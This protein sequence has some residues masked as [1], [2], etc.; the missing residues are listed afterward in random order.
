M[1]MDYATLVAQQKNYIEKVLKRDKL[2]VP[3]LAISGKIRRIKRQYETHVQNENAEE[4]FQSLSGIVDAI[5]RNKVF[6]WLNKCLRRAGDYKFEWKNHN[7]VRKI[8]KKMQNEGKCYLSIV[9]IIKNEARYIREWIAYYRLMGVEHIFLFDNGSTDKIELAIEQEMKS[10]YV[11]FIPFKGANAQLPLYR[12]TAKALRGVSRWVAY[13]DADEFIVPENGNL[14]EY[15]MTKEQFPAIGINWIVYG[16]GGHIKR[17]EGLVTEN[18]RYTFTDKN[19]LLNLRIKCVVDPKEVYDICSPHYCILKNGRYAVD[20][21][22]E[23]IT[24]KWMYVSGSGAA[25]TGENRTQHIRINHYWTKSQEDLREKCNRGYAAGSF[26]PDYESI[27]K[28]LDYPQSVDET[29]VPF[30]EE[31]KKLLRE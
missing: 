30:T 15:L 26:S 9:C 14:K 11:T 12:I 22:G 7:Q 16:P 13:I 23:E 5:D 1:K 21:D 3:L 10:G 25:F 17:P 18:Y 28:R 6:R 24:T 20:E 8:R 31:I 2:R 29:I 4:E 19:N 27:M